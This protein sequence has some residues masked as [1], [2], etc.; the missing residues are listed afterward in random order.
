MNRSE[1]WILRCAVTYHAWLRD[2]AYKCGLSHAEAAVAANCL[3]QNG[4]IQARVFANE[5]DVEGTPSAILTVAEILAHLDGKLRASYEL[6]PQGGTRWES[7]AHADWNRY[8]LWF[9]NNK[10]VESE[11]F[12]WELIGVDRQL[13]ESLLSNSGYIYSDFP[14][15]G[16]EVWDVLEL[17]QPTYWKTLPL[18]HRVRY[19]AKDCKVDN[20]RS[21]SPPD[22]YEAYEQAQEWY[23][24]IKKWYTD[25]DFD[26]KE[27]SIPID[28]TVVNYYITSNETELQK[29]EYLI[30][31]RVVEGYGDYYDNFGGVSLDCNL[32]HN[33]TRAAANSL[34]Q[35]GD[36]LAEV[37]RNETL[38]SDVV[39]TL[40]EIQANLE[41]K[42]PAYYY[43]TPQGGERWEAL[44]S[45]NWNQYYIYFCQDSRLDTIAQ[46][47][48]EIIGLDRQL[49]EQLFRL[50]C[51][52]FNDEIS[53]PGTEVL[54]LVEPWQ[55][56]YWKTLPKAYR[57]RFQARENHL[58]EANVSSEWEEASRQAYQWFSEIQKWYIDP[59]FD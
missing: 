5:K 56:T 42:L 22:W 14:V 24:E 16:T 28:G 12:E 59:K 33:E 11:L 47:E 9:N 35:K 46:Y 23:P 48:C 43:L 44:A 49:I 15:P 39:M 26:D 34:F 10:I 51:Y 50:H 41:G 27:S 7:A 19:Q 18:A 32:S 37:Y 30:M 29:V 38:V 57:I 1:Y 17:W 45:A 31:K 8:F 13:I 21:K 58:R 4:D 54:D 53:I 6:T 3:F 55:A 52:L 36:I 2:V 20:I 25:P 40:S